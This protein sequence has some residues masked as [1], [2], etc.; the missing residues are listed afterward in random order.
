MLRNSLDRGGRSAGGA[1]SAL[2]QDGEAEWRT[3]S[4]LI[5]TEPPAEEFTRYSYVNPDAP[6]GG[7][8]NSA[9]FGTFDSFNPF[10]VRGTPAAGLSQFGGLLWDTLM[11]QSPD[12]AGTSH[13][14]IAEAFTY[15][16]DYSSATY[17]L[18]PDARWHDG[19]PITAEDVVWSFEKL[20]EISPAYSR[21]YAN[22][23]EAVAISEREVEFTFD[24]TGNREL[25]HIMG[26]LAVLPK[27]W[28]EGENA[29][30]QKRNIANPTLEAPLGSGPYRIASFDPGSRIV[31]ERV[32]D[33]W[34]AEEPVNIGRNNFDRMT[35]TYFQDDN[36][37]FLA[38]TRGGFEDIRLENEHAALGGRVQFP[39]LRAR[40]RHQAR[41]H[42]G[43][44]PAHAGVRVQHAPAAL[45]G[46]ARA[47]GADAGLQFRGAEPPSVLRA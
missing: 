16:D 15:P 23:T 11:Q 32:E 19:E 45:P 8:L 3:T 13:A 17:R 24:Q 43:R 44:H 30:G 36:A 1:G 22:V 9:A 4:S 38:F 7:T 40:R 31:W 47:P 33:Y 2:A 34:G 5:Q 27:H 39:G 25:P 26:D 10:I 29:R 6:K 28:W 46:P 18:N 41:V 42:I 12:E 37:E 20:K 21:Y 35:Y 14:L